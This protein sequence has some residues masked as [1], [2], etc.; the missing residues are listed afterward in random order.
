MRKKLKIIGIFLT[1]IIGFC[2]IIVL[3]LHILPIKTN[4][5][6]HIL[7]NI[8]IFK[9]QQDEQY[10]EMY[11][12]YIN[13]SLIGMAEEEVIRQ[14]GEPVEIFKYSDK[15]YMYNAGHIY[16]GLFLGPCNLST[17]K[18]NYVLY[19]TFDETDKVKSTI[20]KERP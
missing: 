20:V 7:D 6:L 18:H 13:N 19:V 3:G 17:E 14:L 15:V 2:F 1:S 5:S 10:K 9:E 11:G 4:Y 12:I 8:T 16:K